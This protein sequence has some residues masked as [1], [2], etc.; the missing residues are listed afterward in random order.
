MGRLVR[1]PVPLPPALAFTYNPPKSSQS[2]ARLNNGWSNDIKRGPG[3]G[4]G[5]GKQRKGHH[6]YSGRDDLIQTRRYRDDEDSYGGGGSN[7]YGMVFDVP[8]RGGGGGDERRRKRS[9]SR[10]RDREKRRRSRSPRDDH[11]DKDRYRERDRDSKRDRD[12][13]RERER[14]R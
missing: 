3:P 9:R 10:D 14:R 4:F 11:R 12:R 5:S 1:P 8:D 7:R 13:D 2:V 6:T